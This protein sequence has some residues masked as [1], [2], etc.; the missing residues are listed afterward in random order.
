LYIN[1][2]IICQRFF[3]IRNY[4][5][6]VRDSV[7]LK[8]LMDNI[9]GMNLS[10]LSGLGMIPNQFKKKSMDYLW[11][12]YKPYI[13]QPEVNIGK[14]NFEK[15]DTFDFEINVDKKTV[16]KST[17]SGNFFPPKVRYQVDIKD[18]IVP[19]MAEI[20]YYFS[21]KDYTHEYAGMAL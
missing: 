5:S 10:N 19:I 13:D 3:P 12:N 11:N 21:L 1:G 4:N 7:E 15:E 8:D 6:D 17:F 9:C 14:N 18:I 20:R 16:A 2:K